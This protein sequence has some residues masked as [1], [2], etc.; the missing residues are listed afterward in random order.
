M[1]MTRRVLTAWLIFL[2]LGAAAV[3]QR[4][5]SAAAALRAAID[6]E[7]VDGNLKGAIERYEQI[8][9]R[10]GVSDRP[11]AAEALFRLA[12]VYVRLRHPQATASFERI[13]RE[14]S[15]QTVLVT[16]AHVALRDLT[17]VS[18]ESA[19]PGL[20]RASRV[21]P[22]YS[23]WDKVSDDG[24]F[25]VWTDWDTGDVVLKDL[26]DGTEQRPV[27]GSTVNGR[28]ESW[29]ENGTLSPDGKQFAYSWF[30]P[31]SDRAST[32]NQ[33]RVLTL[34]TKSSLVIVDRFPEF[35]NFN[36][37]AWSPDG[38]SLLVSVMR[39]LPDQSKQLAW[40]KIID[41]SITVIKTLDPWSTSYGNS[42]GPVSLSPDGRFIAYAARV[43]EGSPTSTVHILAAD[44]THESTLEALAPRSRSPIWSP[45]GSQLFFT[46]DGPG[47][48]GLYRVPIRNGRP[49]G[50]PA[51]VKA[52]MGRAEAVGLTAKGTYYYNYRYD[53]GDR[54]VI[55]EMAAR[56]AGSELH[57]VSRFDGG[58]A[59]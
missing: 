32:R 36:V 16:N 8:V 57:V 1:H 39:P 3:A 34:G 46:T 48:A 7:M 12:G 53:G 59:A 50:A 20:V 15:E 21:G 47:T 27:R 30:E 26:T 58:Y 44:G 56:P 4:T 41:G 22:H 13:I 17:P 10:F 49:D 9:A 54:T 11:V 35:R 14:Y 19:T 28:S 55:V 51:L 25:A 29:G 40:V 33:L 43:R 38:N 18:S 6:M 37:Y 2:A 24:R 45:V 31:G 5:E 52:D 23:A 42:P